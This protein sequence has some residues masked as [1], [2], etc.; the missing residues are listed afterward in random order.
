MNFPSTLLNLFFDGN[1][2]LLKQVKQFLLYQAVVW[3]FH[4]LVISI[5][6]FFHL[7]L[8]HGLGTIAEWINERGWQLIIFSK[9]FVIFVFLQF[10]SLKFKVIDKVNSFYRN[11]FMLP[12][13]DFVT[14]SVFFYIGMLGLGQTKLNDAIIWEF[15]NLLLSYTGIV[16]FFLVDF[17]FLL[18]LNANYNLRKEDRLL[19][20]FLHALIFYLGTWFSFQYEFIKV[21]TFFFFI[22]F[23]LL[24]LGQWR[25]DN[26]TFPILFLFLVI[27]PISTF[28][29]FDPVWQDQYSLFHFSASIN[30][31]EFN[32]LIF[33]SI[34]YLQYK[35]S[36][37]PEYIYRD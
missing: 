29:G 2:T 12:R 31:V 36:S 9:I 27:A 35:S 25:R 13:T 33:L 11:G 32:T 17:V 20:V 18:L 34:L 8:N 3:F 16:I 14:V 10:Y 23:F 7:I 15:D 1:N 5:I 6:S 19:S 28:F 21:D 22:F 24:Y 30:N 26:W 37:K 4:L